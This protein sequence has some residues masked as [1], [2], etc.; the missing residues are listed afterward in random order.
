MPDALRT[1]PVARC[2]A[3]SSR[4]VQSTPFT[5]RPAQRS[6]LMGLPTLW[7]RPASPP[8]TPKYTGLYWSYWGNSRALPVCSHSGQKAGHTR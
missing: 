1:V 7:I 8:L 6:V 5:I 2:N 4:P 3:S